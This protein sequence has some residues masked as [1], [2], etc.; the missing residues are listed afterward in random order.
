VFHVAIYFLIQGSLG[1]EKSPIQPDSWIYICRA[2]EMANLSKSEVSAF[3]KELESYYATPEDQGRVCTDVPLTY[4]GRILLPLLL[5]PVML[6][7]KWWLIGIPNLIGCL[8]ITFA[9]FRLLNQSHRLSL[10]HS[11]VA[12]APFLSIQLMPQLGLVL[13]ET[14]VLGSFLL[15]ILISQKTTS[16]ISQFRA[17]GLVIVCQTIGLLSR[18]S[19]PIFLVAGFLFL[20][21]FERT[22]T[23]PRPRLLSFVV[24]LY[25]PFISIILDKGVKSIPLTLPNLQDGVIGVAQGLLKDILDTLLYFDAF[26]LVVLLILLVNLFIW[27][28]PL[29]LLSLFSLCVISL[30]TQANVYLADYSYGQNWRYWFVTLFFSLLI[31]LLRKPDSETMQ[32]FRFRRC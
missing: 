27:D 11:A 30:A 18:Q 24:L 19:W 15:I 8:V 23:R 20:T 26:M 31:W 21:Q 7:G 1:P 6:S 12:L 2:G 13:T 10:L 25:P 32:Q 16:E 28:S 5:V 29:R 3:L 4:S 17:V 22:F 9:W 14:F